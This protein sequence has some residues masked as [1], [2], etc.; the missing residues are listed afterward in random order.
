MFMKNKYKIRI[1]TTD[2][3]S[4]FICFMSLIVIFFLVLL[5]YENQVYCTQISHNNENQTITREAAAQKLSEKYIRPVIDGL[6]KRR[7]KDIKFLQYLENIKPFIDTKVT[8]YPNAWAYDN[9]DKSFI[10]IDSVFLLDVFHVAKLGATTLIYSNKNDKLFELITIEYLSDCVNNFQHNK[11]LPPFYVNLEDFGVNAEHM[12]A[13][14]DVTNDVMY[15]FVTYVILH[16]MGHIYL[17][18]TNRHP[19]DSLQSQKNELAADTWAF[20]RMIEMDYSLP[21]LEAALA[22]NGMLEISRTAAGYAGTDTHPTWQKRT[23]QLDNFRRNN[24]PLLNRYIHLSGMTVL[25]SKQLTISYKIDLILSTQIDNQ[26]LSDGAIIFASVGKEDFSDWILGVVEY[27]N[28]T[29][30][31]YLRM[32]DHLLEIIVEHPKA[33]STMGYIN[34]R[35]LNGQDLG[36]IPLLFHHFGVGCTSEQINEWGRTG[37]AIEFDLLQFHKNTLS[38][39][40]IDDNT[41]TKAL[42]LIRTAT[43][44]ERRI[45]LRYS[46]GT[47]TES[48]A[49]E[50]LFIKE[51]WKEF[52]LQQLLGKSIYNELKSAFN[53]TIAGRATKILGLR[54]PQQSDLNMGEIS[55]EYFLF[56]DPQTGLVWTK[57]DNL[58]NIGWAAAD[59]YCRSLTIGEYSNWRLPSIDELKTLYSRSSKKKYKIKEPFKL[60]SCY[61]WSST[62]SFNGHCAFQFDTGKE[63]PG[64]LPHDPSCEYR[65]ICVHDPLLNE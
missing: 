62:K 25:F 31:F 11:P 20:Q 55:Q 16:E 34:R 32:A 28:E 36:K 4:R 12:K 52:Q 61:L 49:S 47:L 33:H 15:N 43:E 29:A 17:G 8:R 63:D 54:A 2:R 50:T 56:R 1:F 64:Y 39:F 10:Q 24:S 60:S 18:H 35:G 7:Q 3:S 46:K 37:E 5:F 65:V 51:A 42:K 53:S 44:L 23:E 41:K 9:Q 22:A 27:K 58:E 26:G 48:E 21:L 40:N 45:K 19:V 59:A 13:I 38:S 6:K 57:F 14:E 30:S